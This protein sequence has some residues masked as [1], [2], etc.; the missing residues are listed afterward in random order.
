MSIRV[1]SRKDV[2]YPYE[3]CQRNKQPS[4]IEQKG[5]VT[6][7]S[8]GYNFICE[9]SRLELDVMFMFIFTLKHKNHFRGSS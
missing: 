3:R 7:V 4:E 9:D 8:G 2:R 6:I 5:N 1:N